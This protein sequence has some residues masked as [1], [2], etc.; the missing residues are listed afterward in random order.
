MWWST[1]K[2]DATP[3]KHLGLLKHPSR[4]WKEKKDEKQKSTR[5]K[6]KSQ[7]IL[8]VYRFWLKLL[9]KGE[10]FFVQIFT[11]LFNFQSGFDIIDGYF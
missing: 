7:D 4:Q 6:I 11:I 5:M 3:N 8:I 10:L 9:S 1:M 2:T